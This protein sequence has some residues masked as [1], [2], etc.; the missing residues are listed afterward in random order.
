MGIQAQTPCESQVMVDTAPT[1]GAVPSIITRGGERVA[2]V[3]SDREDEILR[4]LRSQPPGEYRVSDW[5]CTV[6][7]K[8]GGRLVY[9][10]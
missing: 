5:K 6:T 8:S 4:L 9:S 10:C 7:V 1:P 3:D 2:I